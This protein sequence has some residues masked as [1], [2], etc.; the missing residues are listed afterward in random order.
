MGA[1]DCEAD[2]A[3]VAAWAIWIRAACPAPAMSWAELGDG[4]LVDAGIGADDCDA[5]GAGVASW[6]IWACA[7][8]A[9][10]PMSWAELGDGML[11]A[12]GIGAGNGAGVATWVI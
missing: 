4:I 10:P 5:D 1:G 7:T 6:A 9:A 2:G 3:G 11:D 12:A 8:C